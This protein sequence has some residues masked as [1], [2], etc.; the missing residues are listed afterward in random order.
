MEIIRHSLRRA[1]DP[2]QALGF[3]LTVPPGMTRTGAPSGIALRLVDEE[4]RDDGEP[5]AEIDFA[6]FAASLLIDPAGILDDVIERVAGAF[7][8]AP[9][10]GW[11]VDTDSVLI[12]GQRAR[13]ITVRVVRD[14]DGAT[15]ALQYQTAIVLAPPDLA[16]QAA[17]VVVV[18]SADPTWPGAEAALATL[19]L[20]GGRPRISGRQDLTLTA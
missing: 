4:R 12:A 18:R 11:I 15:P 13:R 5:R 1:A 17:L 7:I 9:R 6:V 14:D 2:R 10:E 20:E 16:I 8:E 3:R 19:R